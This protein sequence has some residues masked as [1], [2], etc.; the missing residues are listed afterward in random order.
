MLWVPG[1]S[2]RAKMS[3]WLIRS[4]YVWARA[5]ADTRLS[6]VAPHAT[7]DRPNRIGRHK[8]LFSETLSKT[9]S[10]AST[11][12]PPGAVSVCVESWTQRQ[13]RVVTS[14]RA[15]FGSPSQVARR[16]EGLTGGRRVGD[17]TFAALYATE[18]GPAHARHRRKSAATARRSERDLTAP[19]S[20]QHWCSRCAKV[21]RM[22]R[23]QQAPRIVDRRSVRAR[24]RDA[25]SAP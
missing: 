4:V 12:V 11:G 22:H 19:A 21:A 10:A 17:T 13:S 8:V 16:L 14:E 24:P 1:T 25:G 5:T 9:R 6:I 23:A 15:A 3:G 20:E 7:A 18:P 2:D